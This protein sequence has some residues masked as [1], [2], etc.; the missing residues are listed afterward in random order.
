MEEDM[1]KLSNIMPV[2]LAIARELEYR[3]KMEVLHN[4]QMDF[5]PLVP[6]Q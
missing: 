2:E 6:P 4:R 1:I 5:K 3:K